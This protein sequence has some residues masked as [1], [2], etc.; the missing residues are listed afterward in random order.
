[1]LQL[2]YDEIV[3]KI[4]EEKGLSEDQI[5]E[6]VKEKLTKLSDL[7]SKEG[8][9][10]IV[11]NELGVKLLDPLNK[12]EIKIERLV[13]GMRSVI[14]AGKVLKLYRVFEFNKNGRSGKVAS[15]LIGDETGRVRVVMWDTN[16]ISKME[17]GDIKEDVVVRVKN[18][19]VKNNNGFNE[20]NVG[21]QG[22]IEVNPEGITIGTVKEAGSAPNFERKL[23]KDLN[24]GDAAGVI[25]T[26]TQI[27]EPRFYDNCTQCGKKVTLE[28]GKAICKQ[29]GE[30][31]KGEAA[32]L[33]FFLDDGTANLRCVAFRDQ[34]EKILGMN[35]GVVKTANFETIKNDLLGK[36]FLI[37]GRANK[38][39]MF[40]RIEFMTSRVEE[41]DP[42]QIADELAK[43]I[44]IDV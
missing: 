18:G 9:A 43:V 28:N 35:T 26:I 7:I 37:F 42:K 5:K 19:Y 17:N 34:A 44:K 23:L 10:H 4:K 25:G 41:V 12:R 39:E 32:V 36:Q 6:K 3:G 1:M 8:A 31:E 14:V 27:F 33:N 11:A 30:T 29:H 15:F 21:N 40:N 2:S 22:E 20:V 13:S 16:L 24:S 38:N